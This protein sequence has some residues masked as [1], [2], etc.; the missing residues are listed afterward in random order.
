MSLNNCIPPEMMKIL[1]DRAIAGDI[2]PEELTKML[3]EERDA[4]KSILEEFVAEKLGVTV[5][6]DEVKGISE[7]AKVVD[8]AQKALGGELGNPA[9]HQENV[10]F[11]VAKKAM[12]DY[13]GSL[14]PSHKLKVLTGTIGRGMMLATLKSPILNIGSN[15]EIAI[16]EA[17]SR[18][19][20]GGNVKG[21]N[22]PLAI[23][24][25]KMVNDIYQKSGYD[26]SRMTTLRDNELSGGRF[27]GEYQGAQGP[28]KIRAVGRAVEDIVFK[29]MMGAPDV[30]FS[31]A[32]FADSANLN[33]KAMAGGDITKAT[34]IMNDAMRIE[35]T[36]PEGEALRAQALLD[37]QT[38]TWT[39]DSWASDVSSGIRKIL[40][41]VTGDARAGDYFLPF[42]KTSSNVIATGMDY[43]GIGVPKALYK[44]VQAFRSGDLGT[45]EFR[46]SAMRDLV[47][48]GLG[49][50]GALII[51]SQ[52]SNDDFVGAYDPARAQIEQLRNSNT[53]SI[54][55]GNK[56]ISTDWLGPLAV[57]VTAMMYARKYGN[58]KGE[59][60]WQYA[61]GVGGAAL[62]IPGV[63]DIFSQVRSVA[64]KKT[65]TLGEAQSAAEDYAMSQLFSRLV[66]GIVSDLAK[67]IDAQPRQ[68]D[69][70]V[71]SLISRTPFLSTTLPPK[72][73]I[74][75]E[76]VKGEN[77][78]IDLLFGSRVKT[79]KETAVIK[80]IVRVMD[81]NDKALAF[82]DWSKSSNKTLA[83]FKAKVGGVVY[84]QAKLEYGQDLKA[85][86]EKTIADPRYQ[87]LNDTDKLRVLI[88]KDTDA[89]DKVFRQYHFRYAPDKSIRLPKGL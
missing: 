45:R 3:P 85:Q 20:A 46:I 31:A 71:S 72:V 10:D 88:T 25:V 27:L 56:W 22:N 2:K 84:D 89:M 47:R 52:L 30:A 37:A 78:A 53:S 39:N 16:T 1:R 32:H 14:N 60:A 61:M 49:L 23:S 34:E 38:A 41:D 67:A 79:S 43:A 5:S 63:S 80:E 70:G 57:P 48:S 35:P 86:L 64:F 51:T 12:D 19:L 6:A 36:T 33:A 82:T 11:F 87:R 58:T 9:F 59:K 26:I 83:Q 40:N 13:L 81:V 18:R 42:I 15:T 21:A 73:N 75:G 66:P 44:T 76:K 54:R 50:T 77:P 28:G 69:G 4:L 7:K 68:T 74:F 24:Y 17:L 65:Q 55:V 29:Q 62:N 8:T